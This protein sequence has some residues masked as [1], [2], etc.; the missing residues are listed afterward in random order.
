MRYL[1]DTPLLSACLWLGIY[2]RQPFPFV[3]CTPPME[4]GWQDW[5]EGGC[6]PS[7]AS[8][9]QN[10]RLASWFSPIVAR[11]LHFPGQAP[12][13]SPFSSPFPRVQPL[14]AGTIIEIK[15]QRLPKSLQPWQL[16]VLPPAPTPPSGPLCIS[17]TYKAADSSCFDPLSGLCVCG[18]RFWGLSI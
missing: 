13:A 12:L 11:R 18:T 5:A 3:R 1:K 10:S 8:S 4:L 14:T 6:Q 7:K 15:P 17:P 9:T 2:L 16:S